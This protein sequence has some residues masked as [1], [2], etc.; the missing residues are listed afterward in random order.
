MPA[1][2]QA[3]LELPPWPSP[4]RSTKITDRKHRPHVRRVYTSFCS[5]LDYSYKIVWAAVDPRP[6]VMSSDNRV[7]AMEHARRLNAL[8]SVCERIPCPLT[9]RLIL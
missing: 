4:Q 7:A 9:R 3:K 5:T 6:R 8:V 2:R 1:W